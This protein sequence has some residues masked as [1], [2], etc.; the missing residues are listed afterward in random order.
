MLR[1]R[2]A[3][4]PE[5]L[6]GAKRQSGA[7]QKNAVPFRDDR[8]SGWLWGRALLYSVYRI[9]HDSRDRVSRNHLSPQNG[10]GSVRVFFLRLTD[11]PTQM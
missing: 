7:L 6:S 5:C 4:S 2:S 10:G 8:L 11:T 1:V 3:V 9:A